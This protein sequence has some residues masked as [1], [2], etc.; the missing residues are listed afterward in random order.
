M[1]KVRTITI[2]RFKRLHTVDL[3]MRPLMVMI[4]PNGAGKTSMLD[5]VSLL[6][7]SAAGHMKS[8]LSDMGGIS[9]VLTRGAAGSLVLGAEMLVENEPLKYR[10]EIE[11]KGPSYVISR[12]NLYQELVPQPIKYIES[13]YDNVLYNN[14]KTNKLARPDW[15]HTPLESALSQVPKMYRQPEELRKVLTS[16]TQYHVLDV[17]KRAPV[18]LPQQLKPADL[19]G[20]NG[21][22][23]I[24]F[25]YSLRENDK[26]RYE[27]IEDTLRAA[28]PG[29]ESLNLPS[30]ATGMLTLTW[31]ERNFKSPL[32]IGQLSE[33]TL[34]FIWLVSLLQSSSLSTITM[35]DE[36]EVSLHPE[37]LSLFA[38]LVREA[39]AKTQIIVATHSDRLIRFLEPKE[40]LVMDID[41]QGYTTPAWADSLDLEEWLA[42]YSLDEVWRMGRMGARA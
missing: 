22:D 35:I 38:D 5:A 2:E 1:H 39:S 3:Q 8:T 17:S 12:E 30:A 21:E 37:L 27:V 36:P 19:P 25:L 10:L 14:P 13:Q 34:R 28:F 42:D 32:S 9:D 4:G 31:K 29:F 33:G 23:L 41:E 20:D 7:A 26:S 24:P 11:P 16:V 15:E 6:S 18:K 40:V